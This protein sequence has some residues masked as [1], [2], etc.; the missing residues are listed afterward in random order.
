MAQDL[1]SQYCKNLIEINAESQLRKGK[2]VWFTRNI[3]QLSSKTT[4]SKFKIPLLK[5]VE[6]ALE[7]RGLELNANNLVIVIIAFPN[8]E[9]N[10]SAKRLIGK[11]GDQLS[12][13][14]LQLHGKN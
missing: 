9:G 6:A 12:L 7:L 8:N 4:I 11:V 10:E 14:I 1:V 5:V 3:E 2:K 13:F